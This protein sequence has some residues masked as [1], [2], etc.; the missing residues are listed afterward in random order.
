MR[1]Y[2]FQRGNIYVNWESNGVWKQAKISVGKLWE[3]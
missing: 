1:T 3:Q 2:L